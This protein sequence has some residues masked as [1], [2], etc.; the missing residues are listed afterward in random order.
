M[1]HAG[2]NSSQ[3]QHSLGGP[4]RGATR[5]AA[6]PTSRSCSSGADAKRELDFSASGVSSS[7]IAA[8]AC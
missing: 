1:I 4:G 2:T 8:C 3:Y 7:S 6:P 5:R